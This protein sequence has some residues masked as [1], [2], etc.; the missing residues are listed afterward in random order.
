M[1]G[2]LVS[3]WTKM[4][5]YLSGIITGAVFFSGA[6]YASTAINVDFKP[7]KFYFDMVKKS[8]PADKQGLIYNGTTYVPLR[9]MSESLGQEVNWDGDTSSIYIGKQPD[10]VNLEDLESSTSKQTYVSTETSFITNAKTEYNHALKFGFN[11][12]G[13]FQKGSMDN[14]YQLDGHY[15]KFEALLAPESVWSKSESNGQA[16]YIK[17]Y[18][19]GDLLYSYDLYSNIKEP[20]KIGVDLTGI[21]KLRIQVEGYEVGLI[22]ATLLK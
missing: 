3:K 11:S 16:G 9:F 10:H 5:Y 7:I 8:P 21:N 14:Q 17:I 18:G 15:L 13:K 19:D 1:G 12:D 22:N 20:V 2:L 6:A 4:K